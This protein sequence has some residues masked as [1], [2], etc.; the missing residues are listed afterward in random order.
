MSLPYFPLFP[1][2]FEAKTSHLT[3]AEDGAYNRLLRLAWMTPGCS[4]PADRNWVYRR[5]RA[6]TEADQ[7]VVEAVISEFFKEA[8]G[9]LSNARLTV[10]WLA[11]NDAHER[12]RNAGAKG[13]KA[14]AL[15]TNDVAPSNATPM[16]KQPEPEPEERGKPLS[17]AHVVEEILRIIPKAKARMAPKKTLP[18]VVKTIIAKTPPESLLAAVRACYSHPDNAREAGQYAPAIYKFLNTGMWEGWL[19][20]AEPQAAAIDMGDDQWRRL[21]MT[22]HETQSWPAYA[23]PQP[24]HE[25]C[26]VPE[27]ILDR[28]R[29][30][31]A[32]QSKLGAAA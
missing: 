27:P 13:G 29:T 32:E 20:S 17:S 12:R 11:A 4:I 26:R 3:L 14:K 8:D 2:D 18:K 30:W 9:R 28:Y 25:G 24:G 21:L 7:A 16:L 19:P 15:K 22:W 31:V 1:T 10:E 5:M 23:G 6:L